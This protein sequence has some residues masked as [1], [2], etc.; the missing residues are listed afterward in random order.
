MNTDGAGVAVAAGACWR[1]YRWA[2]SNERCV[3]T[4]E[5]RFDVASSFCVTTECLY[6]VSTQRSVRSH[7]DDDDHVN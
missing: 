7:H 2:T 3:W 5:M 1:H 4:G 6:E